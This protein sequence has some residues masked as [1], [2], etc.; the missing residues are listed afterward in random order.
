MR[1]ISFFVFCSVLSLLLQAQDVQKEIN[2]QVWKPFIKNFNE[3]NTA[4]F[5]AVHS[6][7]VVR[8]SRDSKLVLNWDEYNRKQA[9]GDQQ[10]IKEKRKRTLELRFTERINGKDRAIDVGVYKTSYLFSTG[11]KQDYFGRF[12]V[13]LRKEDGVWKILVDT[14]SSENGTIGEKEFLSANPME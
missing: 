3:H 4:G 5:M 11:R 8:S 6:K 12:H 2:E 10:D 1:R 7:D 14:D 13:V 9:A